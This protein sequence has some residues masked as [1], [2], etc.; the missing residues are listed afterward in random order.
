MKHYVEVVLD[1]VT[2]SFVK[3]DK[4]G[5]QYTDDNLLTT[6]VKLYNI[7]STGNMIYGL[8]GDFDLNYKPLTSKQMVANA[9]YIIKYLM[10][11]L[12][13]T[14]FQAAGFAGVFAAE[15][16]CNPH[17]FN[18]QERAGTFKGSSAN[19]GGYGAGLAQWSNARKGAIM[20]LMNLS[21]PIETWNLDTQLKAVELELT[22]GEK[23][24]FLPKVKSTTNLKDAVHCVLAG[25]ENG[26]NGGLAQISDL[27][28]Y[29]GGYAGMMEKRYGYAQ[30]FLNTLN[31]GK[32]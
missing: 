12:G 27:N 24:R 2:D 5:N 18:K 20:R 28:K 25:Y 6:I 4:Q 13:L 9:L 21:T 31:N 10:Q 29:R 30:Q 14:D 7:I 17:S 32:K 16:G 3:T 26:G 11:H 8:S 22:Q 15:S 23:N 1:S 19:G